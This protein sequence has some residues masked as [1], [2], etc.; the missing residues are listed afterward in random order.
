[1]HDIHAPTIDAV[2]PAVDQLLAKGFQFV[3]VTH[4]IAMDG[5]G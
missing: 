4:L 2:L 3:T 5:K 1:V